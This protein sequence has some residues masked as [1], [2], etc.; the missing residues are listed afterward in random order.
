[1]IEESDKTIVEKNSTIFALGSGKGGVGKSVLAASLGMGLAQLNKRVVVVDGDLS[2]ANLHAVM[3]IEKPQ[4]TYYQFH[5]GIIKKLDDI[6]VEHPR[7]T[8]LKILIGAAGSF[9]ASNPNFYQK[10]RFIRD[11]AE[12]DSDFIILDLGAGSSFNVVDFFLAADQ[13]IVVVNPEPLSILESFNFIKQ[14]LYRKLLRIFRSHEDVIKLIRQFANMPT[15]VAPLAMRDLLGEVERTDPDY[16]KKIEILLSKY[17]PLLLINRFKS[18][19]DESNGMAVVTAAREL[20]SIEIELMGVIHDDTAVQ[21]SLEAR[22]PLV[23]Y[24]SKSRAARDLMGIITSRILHNGD[25][26]HTNGYKNILEKLKIPGSKKETVVCSVRC[27][28]WE[29][30]EFKNEGNPC[31]LAGV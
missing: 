7:Y 13:G 31:E 22:Q 27:M 11:L 26:S 16:R 1:M 24:N 5:K 20:L 12:I 6:L 19:K 29:Q 28:Y 8:N 18:S 14:A 3:G 30:C 21:K 9:D 4:R 25:L 17:R 10:M 23:A 15:N 2:G